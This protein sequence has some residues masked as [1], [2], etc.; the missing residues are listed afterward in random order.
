MIL[1]SDVWFEAIAL[2][3]KR[4]GWLMSVRWSV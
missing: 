2:A 4:R 1:P 3:G